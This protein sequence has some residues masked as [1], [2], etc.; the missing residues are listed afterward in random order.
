MTKEYK[1][2]WDWRDGSAVRALT[3]LSEVLGS[4]ALF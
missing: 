3:V 2:G 1:L 4:D